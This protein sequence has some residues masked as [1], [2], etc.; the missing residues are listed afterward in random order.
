MTVSYNCD[1]EIDIDDFVSGMCEREERECALALAME[2]LAYAVMH[3]VTG[4]ADQ[5]GQEH[6]LEIVN[7]INELWP[8]TRYLSDEPQ[9]DQGLVD[10]QNRALLRAAE[11]L[12]ALQMVIGLGTHSADAMHLRSLIKTPQISLI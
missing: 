2:A 4:F 5:V 9:Q 11:V 3:D 1:V 10:Q 7:K 12:E 8:S 6:G